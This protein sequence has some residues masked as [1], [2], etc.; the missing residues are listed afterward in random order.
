MNSVVCYELDGTCYYIHTG[1]AKM[2][3]RVP[4]DKRD[5]MIKKWAYTTG[6]KGEPIPDPDGTGRMSVVMPEGEVAPV[7][8][9]AEEPSAPEEAPAPEVS[10]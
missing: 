6:K 1:Q 3:D 7:E 10:I 5:R 9:T 2:L 8:E 4:A